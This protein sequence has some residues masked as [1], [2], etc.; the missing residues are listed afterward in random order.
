MAT[1]YKDTVVNILQRVSDLRGESTTNTDAIRIRSLSRHERNVS[2]RRRWN[3]FL[4]RLATTTGDG[5]NDYT[6][7]D[8]TY[9]M[10]E[11]GLFEVFVGGTTEDKRYSI[12][13]YDKYLNA[14]NNNNSDR[15]AYEYYDPVNDL[16][17]VHINPA[18]D[19][20]T[21][22]YYSYFWTPATRTLT[23]EYVYCPN[24]EILVNLVLGDVAENADEKEDADAYRN[25]AEIL[26][27]DASGR[28]D[29]TALGQ[30]RQMGAIENSTRN[31]G[32]GTY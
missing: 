12:L 16:F 32:L 6:I 17:K 5:G 26:F 14:Y 10:K 18:V 19:T 7:G 2:D 8:T 3:I 27:Q 28:E 24:T 23:T 31:M 30:L 22:I 21:T 25:K 9:L 4:R 11:H 20:G 29:D 1:I 13:S 15:I